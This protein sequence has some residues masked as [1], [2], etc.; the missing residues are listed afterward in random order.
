[1]TKPVSGRPLVRFPPGLAMALLATVA[2]CSSSPDGPVTTSPPV[3]DDLGGIDHG[4]YRPRR[5]RAPLLLLRAPSPRPQP[6]PTRASRGSVTRII[7]HWATAAT[8]WRGTNSTSPG[9]RRT[10]PSPAT[11]ILHATA[12]M[13][14]STFHLD[15]T[16]MEV[17]GVEVDG[18]PAPFDRVGSE[19]IISPA[20]PV[21]AGPFQVEVAYRGDPAR[22]H[23]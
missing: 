16:G 8:R 11:A 3:V 9:T 17:T 14:L 15:L 10:E 1:M 6:L 21:A 4:G 19:L 12:E 7:R 23:T 20:E 2:A 13:E 22:C 5:L 18:A